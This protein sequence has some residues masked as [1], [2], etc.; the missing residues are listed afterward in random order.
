[1]AYL[2]DRY[3]AQYESGGRL[4]GCCQ[5]P[6]YMGLTERLM[7]KSNGMLIKRLVPFRGHHFLTKSANALSGVAYAIYPSNI[8]AI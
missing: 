3:L 7:G 8:Y 4:Y 1:V 6:Q 2:F 5:E